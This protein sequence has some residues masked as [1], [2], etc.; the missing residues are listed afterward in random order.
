MMIEKYIYAVAFLTTVDMQDDQALIA[1]MTITTGEAVY[2]FCA[3]LEALE[4]SD[5]DLF[6]APCLFIFIADE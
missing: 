4:L 6:F 1:V 2:D 3:L 5:G